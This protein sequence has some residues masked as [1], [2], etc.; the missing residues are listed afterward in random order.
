MG[1]PVNALPDDSLAITYAFNVAIAIVNQQLLAANPLI[2]ELAVYNLAGDNLINWA[3]D[4][5]Q[6]PVVEV[7]YFQA[8]RQGYGCNSFVAGTISSASDEGTSE[9]IATVDSLTKLTIGQLQNLKTPYGRQYL[10]FAQMVGTNWG[11]S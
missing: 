3:P 8:L 10:A 4:V 11:L 9:S 7:G 2:Y 6:V 1:V 5:P